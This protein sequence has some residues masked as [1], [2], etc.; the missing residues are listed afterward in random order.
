MAPQFT[1]QQ[2]TTEEEPVCGAWQKLIQAALI[3]F[4]ALTALVLVLFGA[5]T[6]R[7]IEA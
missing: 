4:L 7:R 1:A 3:L 5:Y 6:F 2:F